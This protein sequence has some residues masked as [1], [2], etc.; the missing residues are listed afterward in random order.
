MPI[1]AGSAGARPEKRARTETEAP[2]PNKRAAHPP[3][4][5]GG[6]NSEE[7]VF[8]DDDEEDEEMPAERPDEAGGD[9]DRMADADEDL[10][11]AG[12]RSLEAGFVIPVQL[13]RHLCSL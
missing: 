3:Y 6:Y 11:D 7:W 9:D 5:R 2:A 13:C 12:I 4:A 1:C 8:D 10:Q